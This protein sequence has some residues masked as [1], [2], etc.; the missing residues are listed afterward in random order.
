[1]PAGYGD[2]VLPIAAAK[3]HCRVSHDDED[4]L[5]GAL[6]D[7]A[8]DLIEQMSS[9]Y[10]NP[11][12]GLI[13]TG[14][15]FGPSMRLGVGPVSAVT[16]ISYVDASGADVALDSGAWRLGPRGEV[17]PAIGTEWPLDCAGPVTV[18]FNAGLATA[19]TGPGP[20]LVQAV[21]MMLAH[22]YDQ[23]EAVTGAS[24]RMEV[25]LGVRQ[26]VSS[27]RVPVI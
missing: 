10:L 1:M 21:R 18:T 3:L 17:L 16:A 24:V 19:A 14:A 26:L 5:I 12:T 4:D 23:R 6:R 27:A 11:R 13:W 9:V 7:A 8:V 15:G 2:A 20:R 22:F 25:P